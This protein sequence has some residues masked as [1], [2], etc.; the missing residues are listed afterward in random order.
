M[1]EYEKTSHSVFSLTYHLVICVKYRKKLVNNEIGSLIFTVAKQVT[2]TYSI[3]A[4]EYNHDKDHV[5]FLLKA[6]PSSNLARFVG[7]LKSRSSRLVK[8]TFP[9]VR[10]YLWK[11]HFWSPSYCLL[12]TGGAP[13]C[14]IKEYIQQQGR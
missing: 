4:L 13:L 11:E 9:W 1:P 12:T 3:S 10:R 7:V 8:D 14:V 2:T 5:H 6:S